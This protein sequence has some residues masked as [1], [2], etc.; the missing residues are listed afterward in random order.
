MNHEEPPLPAAPIASWLV[1]SKL[2]DKVRQNL[3]DLARSED[4]QH[5]A[6]MPDVHLG[7]QVNNGTV[8]ATTHLVYPQAVGSDLGC[9]L[10]ALGFAGP[11][12]FLREDHFAQDIIQELYRRVPALKHAGKRLLPDS[13]LQMGLSTE[14]LRKASQ[15]DGACQ[16]GTLGCGNHF[17]EFQSNDA[18]ALWVMVHSGSRAMGQ[19]IT[20]HHLSQATTAP[21]GLKYL[22]L[23]KETGQACW[24]D[25]QWA[26][27]Y[28]T[29]SRLAILERVADLLERHFGISAH[30]ESYV[31]CP[32]N[33]ARQETHFGKNL[34]VHRKSANSAMP[35]ELALI[36]GS[37]GAPSYMVCGKGLENSLKSSSHGAG[38]AMSRTEARARISAADIERQLKAVQCDKLQ[39]A[40]LRDEAPAAYR[41]IREVMRAQRDLVRQEMRLTPRLNF[42]YPDPRD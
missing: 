25:M 4:V 27:Q 28:A 13:L 3:E 23:N 20:E 6:V 32:H 30:E 21:T 39:L 35:G 7:R 40:D 42:K 36:A 22:D 34:I 11:A 41:D 14:A 12:D 26:I 9:G 5:I 1:E 31:D 33:F 29:L 19:I 2:P 37:M 10:S 38:R 18:G 17:L 8:V 16:L 15:R 24:H